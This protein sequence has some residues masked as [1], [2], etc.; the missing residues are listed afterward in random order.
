MNTV[1]TLYDMP[2]EW[3]QDTFICC[4]CDMEFM[5]DGIPRYCPYCGVKF[6]AVRIKYP[7]SRGGRMETRFIN[8]EQEEE[9]E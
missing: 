8:D 7:E 3:Y 6:D 4:E 9:N 2:D 5:T 1:I